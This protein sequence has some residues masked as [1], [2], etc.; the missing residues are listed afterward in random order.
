MITMY[1]YNKNNLDEIIEQPAISPEDYKER[2]REYFPPFDSDIYVISDKKYSNPVVDIVT[3]ELREMNKKELYDIGKYVLSA[4]EIIENGEIKEVILKE[5]EYIED[6]VVKFNRQGKIEKIK[7]ELYDLRISK[8]QEAFEFEI[9]GEKYLQYNRTID[10]S[11]ITKVLFSMILN[12]AFG[13][14]KKFLTGQII[15]W[16]KVFTDLLSVKFPSWKFYTV[17]GSEKYAD[18]SITDFIEM[19]KEM[20]KRTTIS[21]QSETVLAHSLL[22][23]T[24]EE[25]KLFNASKEYEKFFEEAILEE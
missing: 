22:N 12:F 16:R 18:V 3:N 25:L 17:D 24:D 13:I 7:K 11:N 1:L 21:M 19:S 14:M 10:Q 15:E 5:F 6:N 2:I 4:N 8:E 23:K 9:K 20:Q